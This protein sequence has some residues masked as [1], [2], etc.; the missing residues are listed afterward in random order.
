M[1]PKPL[2]IHRLEKFVIWFYIIA[3]FGIIF[4]FSN[5]FFITLIPWAMLFNLG[6]VMAFHMPEFNLK[7]KLVFFTIALAGFSIEA[8][9]LNTGMAFD[10]YTYSETLGVKL[11]NTPLILGVNWLLII[12]CSSAIASLIRTNVY[13]KVL[14]ASLIVMVYD[15]ILE[16]IVG[17]LGMWQWSG[18]STPVY[19]YAVWFIV[20]LVFHTFIKIMNVRI[21]NRLAITIFLAQALFFLGLFISDLLVD[22]PLWK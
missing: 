15:I 4:P 13:K 17:S 3:F 1:N 10:N 16:G 18:G 19:N 22:I 8:I 9:G 11:F 12:Y 14:I 5:K 21:W 6:I 7:S 2:S 20:A